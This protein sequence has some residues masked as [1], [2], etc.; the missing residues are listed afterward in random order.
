V[1]RRKLLF[2]TKNRKAWSLFS[3]KPVIRII[4]RLDGSPRPSG[5]GPILE[6]LVTGAEA[7]AYYQ[8]VPGRSF[9]LPK[10][11]KHA[12]PPGRLYSAKISPA[13]W[14]VRFSGYRRAYSKAM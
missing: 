12:P 4:F 1:K 6:S 2:N 3:A 11:A 7:P 10:R 5:T 9:S 14:L 13:L 8:G